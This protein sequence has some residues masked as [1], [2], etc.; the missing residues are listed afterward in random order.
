MSQQKETLTRKEIS[1]LTPL[2]E[3]SICKRE[4]ELGLFQCRVPHTYRPVL[5]WR[6]KVMKLLVKLE[7][8]IVAQT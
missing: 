6:A 2:S 4:K 7:L 5:Y 8:L 1:A 3:F